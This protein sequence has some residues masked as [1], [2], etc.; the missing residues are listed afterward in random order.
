MTDME[1]IK[2]QQERLNSQKPFGLSSE[3]EKVS[4]PATKEPEKRQT[5]KTNSPSTKLTLLE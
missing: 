3:E 5:Q 1:L 2:L 4:E